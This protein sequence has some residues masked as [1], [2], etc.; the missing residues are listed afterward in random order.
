MYVY[1]LYLLY[2]TANNNNGAYYRLWNLVNNSLSLAIGFKLGIL[3][4]LN[5]VHL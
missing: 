4:S 3:R 5:M 2:I 1:K